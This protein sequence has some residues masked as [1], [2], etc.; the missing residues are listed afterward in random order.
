MIIGY[1]DVAGDV[2]NKIATNINKEAIEANV[3]VYWYGGSISNRG[4]IGALSLSN[5]LLRNAGFW[6]NGTE[7]G[8]V[9]EVW[10]R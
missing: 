8:G 1:R 3:E 10:Y 4:M 2:T 9:V 5:V 6:Y 7:V